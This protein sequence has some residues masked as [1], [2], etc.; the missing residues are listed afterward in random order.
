MSGELGDIDTVTTNLGVVLP[1]IEI[2]NI[3]AS[4]VSGLWEIHIEG[5]AT[6]HVSIDGR[7]LLAGDIYEIDISE[8]KL[9]N[10][11]DQRRSA[12]RKGSIDDL[13]FDEFITFPA[14]TRE[15]E[16]AITVFTDVDCAACRKLHGDI[17]EYNQSGITIRYLAYPRGG[18]LSVSF[19]RMVS[20]WCSDD[21]QSALDK[22]MAGKEIPMLVCE[23][24]VMHHLKLARAFG[25]QGTPI[26]VF[27]NGEMVEGIISPDEVLRRISDGHIR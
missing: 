8:S 15:E 13:K 17:S 11:A 5:G 18:D 22:L 12:F 27:P 1:D 19:R 6:L 10:L 20:A 3:V 23:N 16:I 25:A 4:P 9:I 2:E 24:P 7:Y 26:V 14:R 21:G